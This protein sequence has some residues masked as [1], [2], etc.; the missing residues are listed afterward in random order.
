MKP[1]TNRTNSLR[2]EVWILDLE[3][4]PEAD[5]EGRRQPAAVTSQDCEG[6]YTGAL[7]LRKQ[8]IL[9]ASKKFLIIFFPVSTEVST[10]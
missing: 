5:K 4:A 8:F 2:K 3:Q 9:Q 1:K 6:N 7:F 10:M